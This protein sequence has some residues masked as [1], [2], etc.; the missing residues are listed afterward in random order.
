MISNIRLRPIDIS[1]CLLVATIHSR[2]FPDSSLTRLGREAVRRYYV[3]QLNESNDCLAMGAFQDNRMVGYI[4]AGSFHGVLT[5]FL[6]DNQLFLAML[7]ITRPW[8]ALDPMFRDAV[9]FALRKLRQK[10]PAP[11]GKEVAKT[12]KTAFIILSIAVDPQFQNQGIGQL[13]LDAAENE[14]MARGY[15]KMLLSVNP[16]NDT[17][18][19][20]YEK[21][22]W[23]RTTR[24]HRKNVEME[25]QLIP[26]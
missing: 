12:E 13:L 14:A 21:N 10:R 6:N 24:F 3:S 18:I 22:G 11:V 26:G 7:V 9:K 4:F 1:G 16:G 25:K 17:A 2:S 20:F 15:L 8:L 23:Q 19:H 5:S